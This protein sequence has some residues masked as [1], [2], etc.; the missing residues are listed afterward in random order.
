[1]AGKKQKKN[2]E[3]KKKQDIGK[4]LMSK[5]IDKKSTSETWMILNF[6]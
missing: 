4:V 1:M 3:I 5:I 2:C 6:Q